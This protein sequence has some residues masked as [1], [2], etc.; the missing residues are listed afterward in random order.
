MPLTKDQ[1]L[2]APAKLKTRE[3]KVPEWGPDATVTIREL[4]GDERD[5]YD[6][7]VY[8]HKG[9]FRGLRAFLVAMSLCDESGKS[10]GFTEAE[11]KQLGS[12]SGAAIDR[13]FE[14][15]KRLSGLEGEAVEEAEKN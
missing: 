4:T 13:L 5:A 15:A 2:S 10:L 12:K 1:I 9:D 14:A 3:I 7:E 11:I 8:E 6:Q